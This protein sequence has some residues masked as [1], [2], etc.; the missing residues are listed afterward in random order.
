MSDAS[1]RFFDELARRGREP[2]L[3]GVT[4]EVRFARDVSVRIE[5]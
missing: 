2:T 5:P 3:V 4:G 1:E